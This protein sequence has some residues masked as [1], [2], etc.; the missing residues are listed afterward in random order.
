MKIIA[1]DLGSNM[2]L[3]HNGCGDVAVVEHKLF[4]GPRAHRADLTAKWIANRLLVCH[5]A[6]IKFDVA[7]YELPFARGRDATRCLW[8]IAGIIEAVCTSWGMAVLDVTPG[9]IK[10]FAAGKGGAS[11]EEMGDAAEA[12]GYPGGNEHGADAFLLL[13]YAERYIP[14]RTK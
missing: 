4:T 5:E 1:F 12:M 6:R 2:A 8:G 11:K 9:E 14:E 10:K 3:A 13:K 7:V